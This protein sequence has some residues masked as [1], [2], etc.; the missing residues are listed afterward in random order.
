MDYPLY[1]LYARIYITIGYDIISY[2][3]EALAIGAVDSKSVKRYGKLN[4]LWT[5]GIL[6][7]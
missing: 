5:D 4:P 3:K 1:R 6:G 2:L 7:I